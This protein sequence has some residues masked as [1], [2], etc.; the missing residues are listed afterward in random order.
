MPTT[1][2]ENGYKLGVETTAA[3]CADICQEMYGL[4]RNAASVA[5]RYCSRYIRKKYNLPPQEP[6]N[7]HTTTS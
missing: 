5:A 1:D 6:N 4:K 2:F 7:V 3:E